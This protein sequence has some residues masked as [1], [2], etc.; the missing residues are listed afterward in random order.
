MRPL[1]GQNVL[2]LGHKCHFQCKNT[3][4]E[5][6]KGIFGKK[7]KGNMEY[8]HICF[9]SNSGEFPCACLQKLNPKC[10][11]EKKI[12]MANSICTLFCPLFIV[13]VALCLSFRSLMVFVISFCDFSDFNFISK[14][15][16]YCPIGNNTSTTP[17]SLQ[18]ASAKGGKKHQKCNESHIKKE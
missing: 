10:A 6:K 1:T 17:H 15:S 11:C 18:A 13:H 16:L 3:I 14:V 2:I 7:V 9:F 8:A 4:F 5:A 12:R